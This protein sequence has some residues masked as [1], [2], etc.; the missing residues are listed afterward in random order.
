MNAPIGLRRRLRAVG[1]LALA[2]A[3]TLATGLAPL[4]HVYSLKPWAPPKTERP[5][6]WDDQMWP[7]MD[8]E[9]LLGRALERERERAAARDASAAAVAQLNSPGEF[10]AALRTAA[11]GEYRLDLEWDDHH[12]GEPMGTVR[13]VDGQRASVLADAKHPWNGRFGV[14][15]THATLSLRLLIIRRQTSLA[16]AVV[17]NRGGQVTLDRVE[18][19]ENR[20]GQGG[21]AI[22]SSGNSAKLFVYDSFFHDNTA[23]G[24][25]GAINVKGG[26]ALVRNG[27]FVNN[28]A[29]RGG[30]L[31]VSNGA[32]AQLQPSKFHL[33]SAGLLGG[34]VIAAT[35]G[36]VALQQVELVSNGAGDA[37]VAE[38]SLFDRGDA[39]Y[40]SLGRMARK[41]WGNALSLSA[42][43]HSYVAETEL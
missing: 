34:A 32:H 14:E 4:P 24:D 38:L 43:S 27:R 8:H 22:E 1:A 29:A 26:E 11:P 15:G 18:L 10:L 2:H 19:F 23:D 17:C 5:A 42:D 13:V 39:V 21:G 16:G 12:P 37:V 9:R 35:P 3:A 7:A 40:V 30:A 20:A 31:A 41:A 36:T 33:N 25:G 6:H 28:R